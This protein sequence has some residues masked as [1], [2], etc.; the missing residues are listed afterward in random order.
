MDPTVYAYLNSAQ[1][2]KLNV[3]DSWPIQGINIQLGEECYYFYRRITPT[4]NS[5]STYLCINK[6]IINDFLEKAKIPT[7]KI[8]QVDIVN[9]KREYL[10]ASVEHLHF[11]VTIKQ[12]L[13][14]GKGVDLFCNITDIDTLYQQCQLL[15]KE[16]NQVMIEE[17]YPRLNPY[18]FLYLNNKILNVLKLLPANITGNG[19]DNIQTLITRKNAERLKISQLLMPIL[20][21]DETN[22]C[23]KSQHL[24][25]HSILE[26]GK[27][28]NV[29]YSA[30][31]EKGG[32]VELVT[33]NL[34]KENKA[35]IL[36]I[37]SILNINFCSIE[38]RCHNLDRPITQNHGAIIEVN[39]TPNIYIHESGISGS[40]VDVSGMVMRSL[41]YNKPL[42]YIWHLLCRFRLYLLYLFFIAIA[43]VVPSLLLLLYSPVH[44]K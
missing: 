36:K 21:D 30:N 15:S 7:I 6:F 11:P 2:L 8:A 38:I 42:S 33:E 18:L 19:V 3:A 9:L 37:G 22:Q 31:I 26:D 14:E 25:L 12:S 43:I 23:L 35:L 17:H 10:E 13:W 1:K 4:N 27:K 16:Y 34:C 29:C 39:D 28:I 20:L 24:D 44:G 40:T 32:E 5:A 41:I